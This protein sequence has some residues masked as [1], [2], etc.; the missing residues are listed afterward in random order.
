MK[1]SEADRYL[2]ELLS[3]FEFDAYADMIGAFDVSGLES[4]GNG[5]TPFWYYMLGLAGET[6]EY[7]EKVYLGGALSTDLARELGDVLWYAVR[8]IAKLGFKPSA[9]TGYP[10][11][12]EFQHGRVSARLLTH[13]IYALAL[14]GKIKLVDA[15]KKH[16]RNN[17][18][19]V[20]P[21]DKA[22]VLAESLGEVIEAIGDC[23]ARLGFGLSEIAALNIVKLADRARRNV[24]RSEGDNR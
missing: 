16:Y 5:G 7:T 21:P 10:T 8:A 20:I 11:M 24:I 12:D 9:V 3:T 4:Y 15:V 22:W 18:T 19:D 2:P 13:D 6:A 1:A 23:A 17:Q 14:S